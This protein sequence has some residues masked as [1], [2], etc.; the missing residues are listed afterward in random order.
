MP[1]SRATPCQHPARKFWRRALRTGHR[2]YGPSPRVPSTKRP[3]LSASD[4]GRGVQRYARPAS[5][6]T[7]AGPSRR[8]LSAQSSEP[9]T[10]RK[11]RGHDR[12]APSA[13][14]EVRSA[15]LV[16]QP[17]GEI[18]VLIDRLRRPPRRSSAA[19]AI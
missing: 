14:G 16:T 1:D 10:T 2:A 8:A 12:R 5:A 13:R 19:Q 3:A 17:S 18:D 6:G 15:K 4:A 11:R 7:G 9:R